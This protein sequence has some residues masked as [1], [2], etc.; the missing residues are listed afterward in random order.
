[1]NIRLIFGPLLREFVEN[2]RVS[3]KARVKSQYSC[4]IQSL[5]LPSTEG[6]FTRVSKGQPFYKKLAKKKKK[7]ASRQAE[8]S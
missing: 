4:V 7:I 3:K 2:S 8:Y 1:M 6:C 5:T